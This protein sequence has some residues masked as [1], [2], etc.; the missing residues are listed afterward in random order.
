MVFHVKQ[1]PADPIERYRALLERYHGTLDLLSDRGLAE[2]DRL[3]AEAERYVAVVRRVA[4]EARTVLDVGSGAGLPGVVLAVRLPGCRLVLTE[5]R[6]KRASF[7][8]LVAGQLG[9]SNVEVEHG[10]VERLEGVSADVVVAQAVG[11]LAEVVRL[12]RGVAGGGAVYVSRKGPDWRNELAVLEREVGT[13]VAVVAE[14]ALGHR[15][16]LVALRLGGGAACRSSA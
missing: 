6:R 16:T 14:E 13:A 5:R 3:L 15:G 8:A 2:V 11:T 7:L 10:D 12:T 9:L 4:P 1:P